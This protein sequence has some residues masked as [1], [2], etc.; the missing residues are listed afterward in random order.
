MLLKKCLLIGGAP[1]S[2]KTTFVNNN[3]KDIVLVD[4]LDKL[5]KIKEEK[6]IKKVFLDDLSVFC[7]KLEDL[8]DLIED[9]DFLVIA[10]PYLSFEKNIKNANVF[11]EKNGF[12][13]EYKKME[14]TLK[15]CKIRLKE[16]MNEDTNLKKISDGFLKSFF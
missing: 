16:R 5:K 2:G 6:T 14:T 9:I 12:L 8:V 4:S 3:Y 13:V 10:D 7:N 1:C 15:E 11:F